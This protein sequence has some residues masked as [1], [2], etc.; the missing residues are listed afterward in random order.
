MLTSD[1]CK[2]CN[3]ILCAMY[4]FDELFVPTVLVNSVVI[5]VISLQLVICHIPDIIMMNNFYDDL[6]M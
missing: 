6:V 5:T 1:F 3:I 2:S 4:I